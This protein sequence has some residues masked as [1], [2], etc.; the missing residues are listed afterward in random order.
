MSEVLFE[1]YVVKTNR[2]L[3]EGRGPMD[4]RGFYL[5][6]EAAYEGLLQAP[7]AM[8]VAECSEIERRTFISNPDAPGLFLVKEKI[9]GYRNRP[10]GT[11]GYGWVDHRDEPTE[12]PEYKEYLRLQDKFGG[13]R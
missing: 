12:D 5:T 1:I 7:K 10:N 6:E 4:D 2:D 9:Y 8:G 11:W 3:T 13:G